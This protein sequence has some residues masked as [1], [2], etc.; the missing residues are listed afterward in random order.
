MDKFAHRDDTTEVG[1]SAPTDLNI[2]VFDRQ[3]LPVKLEAFK[4]WNKHTITCFLVFWSNDTWSTDIW[5]THR[6]FLCWLIV[7]KINES[8]QH[9]VAQMSVGQMSVGQM[10]VG[11]MSVGQMSV[12][13]MVSD[14]KSWN[15]FLQ[16]YSIEVNPGKPYN[17]E[18]WLR[19]TSLY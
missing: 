6:K 15:P 2:P 3:K 13:Q 4:K 14:Q 18:G 5:S 7:D 8:T 12:G 19:L 11:Q 9:G 1:D 10:S 16:K 17:R